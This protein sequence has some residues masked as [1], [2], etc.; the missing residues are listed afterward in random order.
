MNTLN[1]VQRLPH[2]FDEFTP[3]FFTEAVSAKFPG[4]KVEAIERAPENGSGHRHRVSLLFIM[5]IVALISELRIL[6]T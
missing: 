5:L 6:C 4:A 2:S 1:I 3:D